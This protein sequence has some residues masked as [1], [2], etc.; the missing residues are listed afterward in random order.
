MQGKVLMCTVSMLLV[1]II[2]SLSFA[3]E[4][5]TKKGPMIYELRIYHIMPGKMPDI[6]KRFNDVT[7]RLF[8]K[9]GMHVIGFWQTAVGESDELTYILAFE[10][11]NDRTRKWDAFQADP[12]WQQARVQSEANGPLIARVTNKILRPTPYSPIQ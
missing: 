4:K 8:Q 2:G 3:Q 1:L 10:D 12:E 5:P 6:N 11:M 9:H 7:M